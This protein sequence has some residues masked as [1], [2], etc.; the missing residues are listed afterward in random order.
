[1]DLA[2]GKGRDV[3][4]ISVVLGRSNGDRQL[5]HLRAGDWKADE[6]VRNIL[7]INMA[8][9]CT[10]VVE[11]VGTQDLFAQ[12]L[13][14]YTNVPVETFDTRDTV[15]FH[16]VH[17]VD[18]WAVELANRKWIFP[19]ERDPETDALIEEAI[20]FSPDRHAGDRLM[21]I[22]F[23]RNHLHGLFLRDGPDPTAFAGFAAALYGG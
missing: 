17:G 18:G 1:M 6:I 16:P 21:T 12:L 13:K 5:L 4:A 20:V 10:V 8:F 15:K 9:Q 2:T 19:A 11:N 3:S 22:F 14:A 23:A 7:E